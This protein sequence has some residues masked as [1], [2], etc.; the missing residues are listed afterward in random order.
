MLGQPVFMTI[1][2]VAV[3]LVAG[4][5][6]RS[7]RGL[8]S[9]PRALMERRRRLMRWSAI[10][11]AL[12]LVLLACQVAFSDGASPNLISL[13]IGIWPLEIGLIVLFVG[14]FIGLAGGTELYR[15]G[16]ILG[17]LGMAFLLY[18]LTATFTGLAVGPGVRQPPLFTITEVDLAL[19]AI[20]WLGAAAIA[21]T[22]VRDPSV[23]SADL[24]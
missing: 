3:E 7:R 6:V 22:E 4:L 16:A 20:S 23:R 15:F 24:H 5:L 18:G 19:A 21:V 14:L 12:G 8:Q 11:V 10:L 1:A 2:L 9:V 13:P 17:I